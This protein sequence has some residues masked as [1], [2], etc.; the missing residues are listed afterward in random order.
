MTSRFDL[1]SSRLPAATPADATFAQRV[2]LDRAR[3]FFSLARGNMRSMLLGAVVLVVLMR[4]AG[5]ADAVLVAWFSLFCASVA[6]AMWFEHSVQRQ[7]LTLQNCHRLLRVRIPVG[8][9]MAS[10][11]GAAAL[12]TPMHTPPLLDA[13]LL[14]VLSTVVTTAALAYAVVPAQY[15]WISAAC[16]TPLLGRFAYRSLTQPDPTYAVL[17]LMAVIW[18]AV[19]LNKSR[20]AS[21]TAH[22]ALV[23]SRRLQDEVEEHTRTREAL[24]QMALLDPLTGLANRRHFDETLHRTLSLAG[25]EGS[26]FGLLAVDLDDFKPVNDRFGHPVGDALL[27]SVA[28]RLQTAVRAG[29]F[30][31]RVGGDEFAVIVHGVHNA[32]DMR[33]V[34]QKLC[35]ELAQAHPFNASAPPSR[36]SVG[37]ALFPEDGNNAIDLMALAD[38]RMYLE[39]NAHKLPQIT[40]RPRH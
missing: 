36:A 37:W 34:S 14:L 2:E 8:I 30:C 10:F 22:D 17:A 12:L 20:S 27:Q 7:G 25:R 35:A 24:R 9:W 33:A 18:L 40:R 1:P 4:H 26:Q 31:A 29:D 38:A 15:L 32:G 6:G 23:L 28:Q 21:R 3:I 16:F 39:K 19:V 11:Y 13:L 5:T